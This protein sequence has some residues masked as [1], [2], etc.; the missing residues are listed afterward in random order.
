MRFRLL[1]ALLFPVCVFAQ[2]RV[3][4]NIGIAVKGLEYQ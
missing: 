3:P 2:E 4:V 1:L